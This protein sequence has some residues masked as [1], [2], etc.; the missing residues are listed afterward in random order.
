VTAVIKNRQHLD[1][2][3]KPGLCVVAPTRELAQQTHDILQEVSN[4]TK[5]KVAMLVYCL[6]VCLFFFFDEVLFFL[7]TYELDRL[8]IW[9]SP[10]RQSTSAL[11]PWRAYYCWLP[12]PHPRFGARWYEFSFIPSSMTIR[13]SHLR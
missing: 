5:L 6:F 1:A 11:E 3:K 4:F 12:W 2:V 13:L 8:Y 9:W 7:F 10:K